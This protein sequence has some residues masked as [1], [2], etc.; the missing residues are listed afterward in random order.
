MPARAPNATL[1]ASPQRMMSRSITTR[2]AEPSITAARMAKSTSPQLI[3]R[4]GT[5]P[6]IGTSSAPSAPRA[7]PVVC[8]TGGA[9]AGR[10]VPIVAVARLARATVAVAARAAGER[11]GEDR[12][13]ARAHVAAGRDRALQPGPLAADVGHLR[14][15]INGRDRDQV[16]HRL[17]PAHVGQL[18]VGAAAERVVWAGVDADAAQDA[19]ALV[20]LVFLEDPRLRHQRARGARLGAAPA[21]DARRV[22]QAHVERRGHER[23]EADPHEVVAGGPHDLGADVGAAAAVDAARRLAEDERVAVVADV[24]VV[25]ARDC[26]LYTS[27]SPRDRTRSR[28]P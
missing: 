3:P 10:A 27:P 24:V 26:L 20:H 15:A 16:D 4:I 21:R 28:M 7:L 22:V 12:E 11:R 19:A 8:V 13:L 2:S 25:R 17:L 23:V 6:G 1:M 5:V 18:E 9:P 14:L